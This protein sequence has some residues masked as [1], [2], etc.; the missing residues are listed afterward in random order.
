M[1]SK[2]HAS[3]VLS[4][5]AV[6]F[7]GAAAWAGEEDSNVWVT[8]EG[9]TVDL[10]GH[11]AMFVSDDGETFNLGDLR[12]GETRTFGEGEKQI[13]ATRLG[14]IVTIDRVAGGDERHLEIKCD[15]E[16]D[17][18]QVITFEENPQKVM[19]VVK[20]TRECVDGV[21]DCE[22]TVDVTLDDIDFGEG[23]HA[24]IRKVHC[25]DAGNCQEFEDVH[26]SGATV[27]VTADFDDGDHPSIVI[28]RSDGMD[29]KVTLVCPE[30]DAT[31]HVAEEQAE[32]TFLCPQ[33]SVPMEQAAAKKIIRKI[34]VNKEE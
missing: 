21:G 10:H 6:L 27:E 11:N 18:C 25:D 19:I 20:K 9:K 8:A 14:E 13:T 32:D 29:G 7:L 15:V 17:T 4:L 26:H 22:A 28:M 16:R 1:K 33:H 3:L 31:I 23:A 30:G 12:E 5:A 24:I 34:R 2:L